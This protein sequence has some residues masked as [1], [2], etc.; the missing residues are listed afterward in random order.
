MA[1]HILLWFHKSHDTNHVINFIRII[2]AG[3]GEASGDVYF[4]SN[5]VMARKKWTKPLLRQCFERLWCWN[6]KGSEYSSDSH[7]EIGKFDEGGDIGRYIQGCASGGGGSGFGWTLDAKSF[8]ECRWNSEL[9]WKWSIRWTLD[10]TSLYLF[11][12]EWSP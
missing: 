7:G 1:V 4:T 12:S 5:D 11:I 6:S 2:V 10:G 9:V 8:S 3:G